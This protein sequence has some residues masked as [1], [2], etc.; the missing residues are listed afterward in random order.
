VVAA[1]LLAG[2]GGRFARRMDYATVRSRAM[3]GREMR[4]AVYAPPGFDRERERLPLVVFLH[5]GGDDEASFDR[6]G[7]SARLDEATR[8]GRIPRVVIAVPDGELG[9]W[10]NWWDGSSDYEDWVVE[11]VLPRVAYDYRTLPCPEG[12]HVM[13]VSMGGSGTIRFALHHDLWASATLI[14]APVLDTEQMIQVAENPLLVPII[15]MWRIWGPTDDRARIRADDPF[16]RWRR[17]GDLGSMRLMVAWG[18]EDRG[19]IADTSRRLHRH[20]ERRGV[21]HEALEYEGN[22]SW[23][24][25]NPVI[26][27]ALRRMVPPSPWSLDHGRGDR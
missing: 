11:D 19:G 22:H 26:E 27:E 17:P 7:L 6:A 9:F 13:G 18:T 20:L 24:S 10:A 14:S 1:A 15:P 3:D 21:P 5:G 8:A 23:R 16:A 12:C 2:C 25:W 4:Y